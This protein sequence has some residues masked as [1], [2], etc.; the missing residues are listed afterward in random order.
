MSK[1]AEKNFREFAIRG[2]RQ[3]RTINDSQ[4]HD[5]IAHAI[6][7]RSAEKIVTRL[8]LV[9]YRANVV[10]YSIAYLAHHTESRI[11]L[12]E[13]LGRSI[14]AP[15]SAAALEAIAPSV[16]ATITEPEGGGNAGEWAKRERCWDV[17]RAKR[18][19]LPQELASSLVSV[20]RPARRGR[21]PDP[22]TEEQTEVV[23][24]VMA[25]DPRR[26]VRNIP[27]GARNLEP[28]GMA[29]IH[30]VQPGQIGKAETATKLQ[31]GRSGGQ[32]P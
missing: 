20:D 17:I 15:G 3:R 25:V 21:T 6:L 18:I 10:A 12:A 9:G 30:R 7:F 31:T 16:Y 22:L 4:Y 5:I 28:R 32:D 8:G 27:L 24:R 19:S 14:I 1:G 13:D 29:E 26:L 23:E 2:G 11:D